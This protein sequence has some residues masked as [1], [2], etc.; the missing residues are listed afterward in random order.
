MG[1]FYSLHAFMLETKSVT[2]V[3]MGLGLIALGLF[4]KFL[5][6]RDKNLRN[7]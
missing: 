4:W 7:Y 2:Y 1:V 6:G 3:L 5:S